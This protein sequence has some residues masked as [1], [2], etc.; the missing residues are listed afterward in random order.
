M[1][2]GG[3]GWRVCGFWQ[4]VM[5]GLGDKVSTAALVLFVFVA[6]MHSS[7]C[8]Y[9]HND[10]LKVLTDS[11]PSLVPPLFYTRPFSCVPGLPSPSVSRSCHHRYL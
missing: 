6:K 5:P 2:G 7:S 1:R 9:H 10:I 11:L 4:R 3:E 8:G